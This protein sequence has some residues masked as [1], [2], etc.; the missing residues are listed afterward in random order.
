MVNNETTIE[1]NRSYDRI[2]SI[3]LLLQI[4]AMKKLTYSQPRPIVGYA[5]VRACKW[6]SVPKW[7]VEDKIC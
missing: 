1:H 3:E 7:N 2:E 5:G 4:S 6:R